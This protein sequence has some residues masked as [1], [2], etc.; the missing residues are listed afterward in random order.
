[1]GERSVK[2]F[3]LISLF[4]VYL[5]E[6]FN[7]VGIPAIPYFRWSPS[8]NLIPFGDEKNFR[9][10]F[11]IGM[12]AVM[13]LPFGFLMPVLWEAGRSWKVTTLAGFAVSALIEIVQ[14]FS[15]RATDVD[16]LLM[17]TLGAFLGYLLAWTVFHQKWQRADGAERGKERDWGSLIFSV[18]NPLLVTVLI[19]SAV[20]EWIYRLPMFG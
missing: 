17:N 5:C 20:S 16:D 4:T 13:F 19:R 8:V 3:C 12:N 7:V 2:R 10:F 9:F 18:L 11:Q 1:R 6:M 15:F 14:L